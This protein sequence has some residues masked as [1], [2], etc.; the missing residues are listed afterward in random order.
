[1]TFDI[2]ASINKILIEG[3]DRLGK[4]TLISGILNKRG[5]HQVMHFSKPL[6]L[7]CYAQAT[8]ADSADKS[9][10]SHQLREYQERSFRNMFSILRDAQYAH[11]ICNRAHLGECVYAPLYRGY[12]GEYVF[13]LEAQ[14]DMHKN[15]NT[16]LI[17]L[18]EDFT[19][20]RHFVD[21]GES[22]DVSMR[23]REQEKFLEA[24]DGSIIPNKKIICV[25]DRKTGN[26]KPKE[27]IL[28]EALN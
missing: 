1:M 5:Y 7:E 4:D 20:S 2:M 28:L 14:F 10:I 22:F 17:L 15:T 11:M 9:S 19:A 24:F 13:E 3:L 26:F 21:D 12:A 23:Q 18:T 25:T 6:M 27:E 16:Q 8:S